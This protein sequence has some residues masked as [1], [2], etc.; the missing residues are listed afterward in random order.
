VATYAVRASADQGSSFSDSLEVGTAHQPEG[1]A[2]SWGDVT[3][4]PEPE[5][6]YWL[7]PERSTNFT[8]VGSAIRTFEHQLLSPGFPPHVWIDVEVNQVVNM[9]DIQ[10]IV[11]AFEG[12]DYAD[13]GLPLI[14][15]D[16]AECP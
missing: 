16:P 13:I 7:P 6:G 4:G 15:I 11:N 12:R 9:S 1:E 3:G 8:D 10:F 14:G 5:M 2:Q